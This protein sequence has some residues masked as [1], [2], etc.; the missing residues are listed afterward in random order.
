MGG[1]GRFCVEFTDCSSV[2]D[3]VNTIIGLCHILQVTVFIL[4]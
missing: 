3:L 4:P 1:G 2:Y